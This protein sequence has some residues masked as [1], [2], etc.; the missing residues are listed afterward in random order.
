[1]QNAKKLGI[2][3]VVSLRAFHSDRDEIG[4]T[5]LAYEH[6]SFKTWHPEEEDV[7][8]F[9]KIVTDPKQTPVLLHCQHG[10]DRTGMMSAIYRVAVQGWT[11]EEAVREMTT[12]DFGFH[13]VW[14]NLPPWIMALDIDALKT[15]AGLS[16]DKIKK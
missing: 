3:T 2:R 13:A 8:R 11:K 12:G 9:L 10:A 15:K 16:P 14:K 5:G 7:V 4:E 6:F 1:M